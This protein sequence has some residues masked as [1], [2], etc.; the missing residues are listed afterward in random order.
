MECNAERHATRA[1][2]PIV[3]SGRYAELPQTSGRGRGGCRVDSA[4]ADSRVLHHLPW[5]AAPACDRR[6]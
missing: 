1:L 3:A 5:E 4:T 6:R 2:A